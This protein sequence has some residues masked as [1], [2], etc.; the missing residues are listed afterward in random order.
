MRLRLCGNCNHRESLH[1]DRAIGGICDGGKHY[2][3]T[4]ECREW[5]P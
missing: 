3:Y 1:G 4:C 5:R 2:P